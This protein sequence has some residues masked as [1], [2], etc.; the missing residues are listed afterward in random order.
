M[1]CSA[2]FPLSCAAAKIPLRRCNNVCRQSAVATMLANNAQLQQCLQTMRS[3]NDACKQ[4]TVATM[5]ANNA[6]LQQKL[7]FSTPACFSAQHY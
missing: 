5:L 3:C 6:Q 7:W 1:A 2:M 4:C